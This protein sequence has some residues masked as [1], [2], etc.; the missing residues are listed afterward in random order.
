MSVLLAYIV[1][2]AVVLAL[3]EVLAVKWAEWNE[4]LDDDE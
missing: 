2:T 3:I 1:G 4:V